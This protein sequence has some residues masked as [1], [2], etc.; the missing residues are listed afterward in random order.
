[1]IYNEKDLANFKSK[2]IYE[3]EKILVRRIGA[4]IIAVYDHENYYNV[5]DVYNLLSKGTLSLKYLLALLN[6]KLMSFYLQTK[7]KNSKK[8]FPKIPIKYLEKLPI[9]SLDVTNKDEKTMHNKIVKLVD[10]LLILNRELQTKE[11][12]A[13]KRATK[14]LEQEAEIVELHKKIKRKIQLIDTEVYKLYDLIDDDIK[15]IDKT[16]VVLESL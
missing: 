3:T 7:F 6:S 16:Y 13:K 2:H 11:Q 5:C 4:E 9:K 10:E 12:E 1:V 8:I 14:N 15:I